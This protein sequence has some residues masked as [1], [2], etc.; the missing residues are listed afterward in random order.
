MICRA[1]VLATTG[2]LLGAGGAQAT[3]A[4]YSGDDRTLIVTGGDDAAHEIQ[5]RL[6]N[7][8]TH[9][10]ILDTVPFTSIPGDCDVVVANT[11]ISC[12]GHS[13]SRST[14]AAATT[15]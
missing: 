7:D 8:Q 9:D 2:L 15:T 1:L 3:T 5:F 14:S 10:E 11:W 12:P 6:S 13:K 4:A